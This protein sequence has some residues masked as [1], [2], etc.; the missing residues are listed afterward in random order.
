MANPDAF[1][2]LLTKSQTFLIATSDLDVIKLQQSD[3]A[4]SSIAISNDQGGGITQRLLSNPFH[5]H[6]ESK[7]IQL[8]TPKF[9]SPDWSNSI[10]TERNGQIPL[11]VTLKQQPN[12]AATV[13]LKLENASLSISHDTLTFSRENWNQPQVVWIDLNQASS[14]ATTVSINLE[15]ILQIGNDQENIV[16]DSFNFTA[17]NLNNCINEICTIKSSDSSN[18]NESED[19]TQNIDL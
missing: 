12:E 13:K 14:E 6:Q 2:N 5:I 3:G 19:D 4:L 7:G 11:L 1:A 16:I 9:D 10:P 8:I 18:N 17:P 15:A